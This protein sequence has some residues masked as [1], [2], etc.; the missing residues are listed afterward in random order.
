LFSLLAA[1]GKSRQELSAVAQ[2]TKT[3]IMETMMDSEPASSSSNYSSDPTTFTLEERKELLDIVKTKDMPKDA[4]KLA[5]EAL[6]KEVMEMK[7]LQTCSWVGVRTNARDQAAPQTQKAPPPAAARPR[8]S[9]D[10]EGASTSNTADPEG[11]FEATY[12]LEERK[13]L[14]D[15]LTTKDTPKDVRKRAYEAMKIFFKARKKERKR[16]F[17]SIDGFL[18]LAE[19][20]QHWTISSARAANY[21]PGCAPPEPTPNSPGLTDML[22]VVAEERT[23]LLLQQ[24]ATKL[25]WWM[26]GGTDRQAEEWWRRLRTRWSEP[27]VDMDQPIFPDGGVASDSQEW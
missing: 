23:D 17:T 16:L 22:A 14:L 24:A 21:E 26:R 1:K 4:R 11:W 5:Y 3:S 13:E 27:E 10:P 9:A 15:I 20:L 18:I 2:A 8:S 6:K 7:A 25:W 19:G 12:T